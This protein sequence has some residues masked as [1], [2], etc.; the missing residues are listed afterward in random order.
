MPYF[1]VIAASVSP[2]SPVTL[3][4]L[5]TATR[6]PTT[7]GLGVTFGGLLGDGLVEGLGLTPGPPLGIP[8]VPPEPSTG[9]AWLMSKTPPT[10]RATMIANRRALVPTER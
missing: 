8:V 6:T 9:K 1:F 10:T 7:C 2:A 5:K 4:P 3:V